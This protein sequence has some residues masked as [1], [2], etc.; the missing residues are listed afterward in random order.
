MRIRIDK[1]ADALYLPLDTASV[2]DSELVAPGVVLD[3]DANGEVV[4]IE[5][6]YLSRRRGID[7]SQLLYESAKAPARSVHDE[8]G[9]SDASLDHEE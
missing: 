2:V 6:L 1:E 9:T 4:G 5:V 8:E 7:L 3:Y